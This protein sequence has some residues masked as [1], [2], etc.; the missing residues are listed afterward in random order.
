MFLQTETPFQVG[1]S[2][3]NSGAQSVS[4]PGLAVTL[5]CALLLSL[6]KKQGKYLSFLSNDYLVLSHIW[7]RTGIYGTPSNTKIGRKIREI[8][9]QIYWVFGI[10]VSLAQLIGTDHFFHTANIC[11]YI[12][13]IYSNY[14]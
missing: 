6:N 4:K 11:Q 5:S 1:N 13:K 10:S 9:K 3:V 14:G 8:F 12:E 2:K 7:F